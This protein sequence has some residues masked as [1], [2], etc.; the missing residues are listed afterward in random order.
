MNIEELKRKARARSA[1]LRRRKRDERF[2]SVVGRLVHEGLLVANHELE[3][4]QRPISVFDALWAGEVEPRVLELLPALLVKRPALF[5][6]GQPLPEDLSTAVSDLR[7]DRIPKDF[8]G[9][10][11]ADVHRWL[12]RVGRKG[13]VPSLLKSFRLTPEDQR[14]LERLKDT[15]GVSE[16]EVI[17]RGLRAL[18]PR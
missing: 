4:N 11:G 3:R 6:A 18:V 2:T 16:T 1:T 14:L 10:P 8:R 5:E 17:R 12:S 9:I 7:R 13:K 15:L